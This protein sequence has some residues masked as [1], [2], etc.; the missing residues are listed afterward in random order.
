MV[1]AVVLQVTSYPFL[2][3][4][5]HLA[6]E[7]RRLIPS[8]LDPT[9]GVTAVEQQRQEREQQLRA[10]VLPKI[11]PPQY[12]PDVAGLLP[13]SYQQQQMQQYG[14]QQQYSQQQQYGGQQPYLQ[15]QG[16]V[17]QRQVS[18]GMV[19]VAHTAGLAAPFLSMPCS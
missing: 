8:E 18:S 13:S 12:A 3:D 11:E 9:P 2:T 10:P 7:L 4:L 1:V 6:E 16:P 15:Q 14:L 5:H 19:Q 17:S